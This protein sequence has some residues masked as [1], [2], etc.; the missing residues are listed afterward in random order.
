[1]L[2][3][4]GGIGSL[5]STRCFS[6]SSVAFGRAYKLVTSRQVAKKPQY[7]A[8]DLKPLNMPKQ[9]QQF[10]DYK[11]GEALWYKQS[12][13][14]LY[15]GQFRKTGHRISEFRNKVKRVFKPNVH[16]KRLWSEIL[17]RD[18]R[19]RLTAR[20]LRTIGK[21]GGV[22]NYILKDKSARMKELG[23][24]GW[25]LRYVLMKKAYQKANPVHKDVKS[26]QLANGSE[27]KNYYTNLRAPGYEGLVTLGIGKRKLFK[28]LMHQEKTHHKS[29]GETINIKEIHN[30]YLG[31]SVQEMLTALA[32]FKYDLNSILHVPQQTKSQSKR[33]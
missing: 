12:N 9:R 3:S 21:E 22:D 11:Y 2:K 27:G 17:E 15:G 5:I 7:K 20:V 14:G 10:P 32:S 23:P 29:L 19:I 25:R 4:F 13:R 24:T 30:K 16:R 28:L 31:Y 6:T 1:M 33:Q 18:I 8:G 26:V